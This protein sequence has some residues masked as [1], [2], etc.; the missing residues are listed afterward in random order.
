M[1]IGWPRNRDSAED[2][3]ATVRWTEAAAGLTQRYRSVDDLPLAEAVETVLRAAPEHWSREELTR[4]MA[5]GR[6][7]G[8]TEG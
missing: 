7:T 2:D 6:E 4:R 8:S 3:A 1:G 5:Q